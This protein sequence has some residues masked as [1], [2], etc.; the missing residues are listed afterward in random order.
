[1]MPDHHDI[2]HHMHVPAPGRVQYYRAEALPF[3]PDEIKTQLR[4]PKAYAQSEQNLRYLDQVKA[5]TQDYLNQN[6][7]ENYFNG[8]QQV[9]LDASLGE[10]E[11]LFAANDE[12][13]ALA[14]SGSLRAMHENVTA[15]TEAA[16]SQYI[17]TKDRLEN[18]VDAIQAKEDEIIENATEDYEIVGLRRHDQAG[19]MSLNNLAD[20]VK[21]GTVISA[22]NLATIAANEASKDDHGLGTQYKDLVALVQ[23][24]QAVL[25]QLVALQVSYNQNVETDAAGEHDLSGYSAHHDALGKALSGA[26]S[27]SEAAKL[28]NSQLAEVTPAV[29]GATNTFVAFSAANN[30]RNTLFSNFTDDNAT[31]SDRL[32]NFKSG[33]LKHLS[34]NII[35]KESRHRYQKEQFDRLLVAESA[36]TLK[37]QG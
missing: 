1:M 6:I 33:L 32:D 22:E 10:A 30:E 24:K 23:A 2:C 27:T 8:D 36:W 11:V 5:I 29:E 19:E 16:E 21:G 14:D 34:L 31:K 9:S 13:K 26:S 12:V 37:N 3:V 35:V 4:F 20:F 28:F 7:K 15:L 25:E 18:I 17:N